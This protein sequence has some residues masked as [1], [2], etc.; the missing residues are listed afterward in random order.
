MRTKPFRSVVIQS[1][2]HC[3]NKL[4]SSFRSTAFVAIA[5]QSISQIVAPSA[6]ARRSCIRPYSTLHPP[7]S[8]PTPHPSPFGP[9]S[10]RIHHCRNCTDLRVERAERV[11]GDA[12]GSISHAV[13][14]NKQI[15]LHS[16]RTTTRAPAAR[17]PVLCSAYILFCKCVRT[18]KTQCVLCAFAEW[19]CS[20]S[21]RT[22][23]Y[24]VVSYVIFHA[25]AV[26]HVRRRRSNNRGDTAIYAPPIRRHSLHTLCV[27]VFVCAP[28]QRLASSRR[29]H[30]KF[31]TH[32][33]CRLSLAG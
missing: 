24:N 4:I 30:Y 19:E 28:S 10:I 2:L 32:R 15:N 8:D 25:H 12:G 14:L 17:A 3:N 29:Y 27:C 31:A 1:N 7:K 33:I 20:A 18:H 21:P 9:I 13:H 5:P 16:A 23:F 22:G 26:W 11:V 6:A